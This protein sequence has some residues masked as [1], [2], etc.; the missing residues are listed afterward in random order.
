MSNPTLVV[1]MYASSV[2]NCEG[3]Y[4]TLLKLGVS[5]WMNFVN[6]KKCL[7]VETEKQHRQFVERLD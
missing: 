2:L 7:E 5:A 3:N 4:S 1:A 6:C